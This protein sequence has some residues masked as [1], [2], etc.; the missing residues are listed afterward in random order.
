MP[1]VLTASTC[2]LCRVWWCSRTQTRGRRAAEEATARQWRDSLH[3]FRLADRRE[4]LVDAHQHVEK[5]EHV[6]SGQCQLA[7]GAEEDIASR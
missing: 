5:H 7:R 4:V 1:V 3:A 6:S 2:A